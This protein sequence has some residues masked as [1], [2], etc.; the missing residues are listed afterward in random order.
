MSKSYHP[1]RVPRPKTTR[2]D[3][4]EQK[5]ACRAGVDVDAHEGPPDA[6]EGAS[7]LEEDLGYGEETEGL[8]GGRKW[9]F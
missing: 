3:I 6:Q 1:V 7:G 8:D 4:E 5:R 9:S 2:P